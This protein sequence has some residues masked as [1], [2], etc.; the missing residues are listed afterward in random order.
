MHCMISK[1]ADLS[2]ERI[3][4]DMQD[5]LKH[6]FKTNNQKQNYY[7]FNRKM[8]KSRKDLL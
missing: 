8:V 3:N 6:E 5:A 4:L 1:N 7:N 2:D